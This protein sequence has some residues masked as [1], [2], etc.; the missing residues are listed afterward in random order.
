[1]PRAIPCKPFVLVGTDYYTDDTGTTENSLYNNYGD[2]TIFYHLTVYKNNK[3]IH[4]GEV[5][6]FWLQKIYAHN[7]LKVG[8]EWTH[9]NG[10]SSGINWASTIIGMTADVPDGSLC[11]FHENLLGTS[12]YGVIAPCTDYWTIKETDFEGFGESESAALR[13]C[14]DPDDIGARTYTVD[15]CTFESSQ[16]II[17]PHA[18]GNY[19]KMSIWLDDDDD[20]F[21]NAPTNY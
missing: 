8:V 9:V 11:K 2:D 19:R 12:V 15:N 3:G 7:N 14:S 17:S 1:V 10:F 13:D 4:I 16:K 6:E 5:G 21:G 18:F 20:S